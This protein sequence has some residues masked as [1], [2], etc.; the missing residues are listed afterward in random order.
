[1]KEKK[2][3]A[4]EE[5]RAMDGEAFGIVWVKQALLEVL[6]CP[7]ICHAALVLCML[8]I[9]SLLG[10]NYAWIYIMGFLFLYH[11]DKRHLER[12][13]R[14]IRHQERKSANQKKLLSDIETAR[15]LNAAVQKI[16]PVFLE[17][18]VSQEFLMPLA[19]FFLEKYKPWTAKKAVLQRL[20]LGRTPPMITGIR[21]L[22]QGTEDDHLVLEA[23]M[24]F[25]A[26]DD[27][28]AVV[29]IQ[30]RKYLTFGLWTTVHVSKLHLEGKVRV[31]VRFLG[32]WPFMSRV[33]ICF[34]NAPYI[35]VTARPLFSHGIDVA[36]LPGIANWLDGMLAAA[37]EQTV[38][39]PNILVVDVER[40]AS[41]CMTS[42]RSSSVD[43]QSVGPS[44]DWFF[45]DEKPA[46]AS[47]RVEILEATQL[48]PS[49]P[50]G[51]ADPY[52]KLVANGFRFKT[53]IKKKTLSPKWME[54]FQ[55]P[56][57]T[58]ELKNLLLLHVRDKDRFHDDDLGYCDL[59][60]AKYRGGNRHEMYL[61]LKGVKTGRLRV[62]ITV[63]DNLQQQSCN[64]LE[65]ETQGVDVQLQDEE[66]RH[67]SFNAQQPD[68]RIN[69]DEVEKLMATEI[70]GDTDGMDDYEGIE[71]GNTGPGIF[72]IMRPGRSVRQLWHRRKSKK[73][74]VALFRK[75][76]VEGDDIRDK[77]V[78]SA[79]SGYH[80]LDESD[81]EEC[82]S[83]NTHKDH[84]R[85]RR[86]W[87]W[88]SL[89][90]ERLEFPQK[91]GGEERAASPTLPRKVTSEELKR[92]GSKG[93]EVRVI[94]E[95]NIEHPGLSPLSSRA[96]LGHDKE[97][98]EGAISGEQL[99]YGKR[100]SGKRLMKSMAKGV[101]R[102]AEKRAHDL[103]RALGKAKDFDKENLIHGQNGSGPM[104]ETKTD[105][106]SVELGKQDLSKAS[107]LENE[108]KL[109]NLHKEQTGLP[110]RLSEGDT[111]DPQF[112]DGTI[113]PESQQS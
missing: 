94:L 58:W 56:V 108:T 74:D 40:L 75:E 69:P 27:M 93:T 66:R 48:K 113:T 83:P 85:N 90:K 55:I 78:S 34:E 76:F 32:E 8:W 51:L 30:M 79:P 17:K 12:T 1:M 36:E 23:C 88:W 38:V 41:F 63:E 6:N 11:I 82:E 64:I 67:V 59:S 22:E 3:M 112:A 99:H 89:P 29:A 7:F 44:R 31:G 14:R 50:N 35:Q 103:G 81:S 110:V 16:W 13:H 65:R 54:V 72:S 84:L 95:G 104:V 106:K 20:T 87:N 61:P 60:L 2:E 77:G 49:D 98:S 92:L 25:V 100:K 47:V 45:I 101:K 105:A 109:S 5:D 68:D 21:A 37:L 62:A 4:R 28:A 80:D 52:V 39:A 26:A 111:L 53:S 70:P 97:F 42:M 86:F 57:P 96:V 19:P 10:L 33:R 9:L 43:T 24:E 18:F 73:A 107:V 15:W 46:V 102:G 91:N 71:F